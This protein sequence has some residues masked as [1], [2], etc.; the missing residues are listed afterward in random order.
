VSLCRY[1]GSLK[2]LEG[3]FSF[4]Q[5]TFPSLR[6]LRL[7]CETKFPTRVP[8]ALSFYSSPGQLFSYT[9]S[10]AVHVIVLA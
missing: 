2:P 3:A 4:T 10:I 8:Y 5:E 6:L 9:L 1:E 7:T